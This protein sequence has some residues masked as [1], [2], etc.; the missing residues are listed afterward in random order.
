MLPHF[1]EA[2]FN[3]LLAEM[4]LAGWP[5]ERGWFD[6]HLEF[7]FPKLGSIQVQ[8]MEIELR[9]ALEPWHVL[10]EEGAAGGVARYVDSSVERLQVKARGLEHGRYAI[11]CNRRQLP[12]TA[13]GVVG[14]HVAAVRFKAWAPPSALHPTIGVHAPLIFDVVDLWSGR[15]VGGCT[16]H[17]THP[18]G[19][20]YTTLPV[21]AFEAESRR[22]SRFFAEGHSAE[23][24]V[25]SLSVNPSFPLTLDLRRGD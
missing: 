21:N 7:R 11:A 3:D 19:L 5:L 17:V 4:R 23:P 12:M 15:A 10:G 2:D 25:P 14:E 9:G 24:Y 13:T 16:Y 1:I 8:D 20:N 18:G 22:Q 6:P